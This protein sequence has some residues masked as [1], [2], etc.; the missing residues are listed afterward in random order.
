MWFISPCLSTSAI[1][2]PFTYE[3][4]FTTIFFFFY[5]M[6]KCRTL[7]IYLCHKLKKKFSNISFFNVRIYYIRKGGAPHSTKRLEAL[8]TKFRSGK[9]TRYA[10]AYGDL[11]RTMNSER[12]KNL[13]QGV[14]WIRSMSCPLRIFVP[15]RLLTSV[16]FQL[17]NATSIKIGS[18][19]AFSSLSQAFFLLPLFLGLMHFPSS[20]SSFLQISASIH[21]GTYFNSES[22]F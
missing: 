7:D 17:C 20:V 1:F 13:Q 3:I 14:C 8:V 15:A 19:G 6:C 12:C 5:C 9:G 10:E 4:H 16:R 2:I 11:H 21:R 22:F 18:F